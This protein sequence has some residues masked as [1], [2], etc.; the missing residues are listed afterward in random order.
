MNAERHPSRAA[1]FLR[2]R[3]SSRVSVG[4]TD[5]AIGGG[6][7]GMQPCALR[8]HFSA[9]MHECMQTRGDRSVGVIRFA[10]LPYTN[11]P[12]AT[13]VVCGVQTGY[14]KCVSD[15]TR[16]GDALL[17]GIGTRPETTRETRPVHL[18]PHAN[19]CKRALNFATAT[20]TRLAMPSPRSEWD[21]R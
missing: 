7:G 21:A 19:Q 18:P 13:Q 17:A 9:C 2:F 20:D 5:D 12:P 16:I 3:Y 11:H 10:C 8:A 14:M 4:H 15:A 1:G 6:R